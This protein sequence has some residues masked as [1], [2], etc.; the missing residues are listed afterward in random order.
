MCLPV[1]SAIKKLRA[2]IRVF[3]IGILVRFYLLYLSNSWVV[4]GACVVE[5]N[6]VQENKSEVCPVRVRTAPIPRRRE[7]P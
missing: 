7:R 2:R 1:K 6:E 4:L 5:L 3:V